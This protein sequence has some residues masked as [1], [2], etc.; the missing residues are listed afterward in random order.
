MTPTERRLIS[1]L[2]AVRDMLAD[3]RAVDRDRVQSTIC[4]TLDEAY[5]AL[6]TPASAADAAASASAGGAR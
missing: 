1:A 4:N 3:P 6:A 5:T 2:E